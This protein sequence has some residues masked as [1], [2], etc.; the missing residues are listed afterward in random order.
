MDVFNYLDRDNHSTMYTYIKSAHYTL[1]IYTIIC[2]LFLNKVWEGDSFKVHVF[3]RL[4]FIFRER[5]RKGGS[6]TSMC[7]RNIN[8]LPLACAPKGKQAG[9]P[10]ICPDL[11]SNLRPSPLQD[12]P[13]Q[14]SPTSQARRG[15]F[16]TIN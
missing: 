8:W 5:G 16:K 14:L 10:G 1:Q 12:V 2:Q 13:N 15:F 9:N 4:L 6:D 3:K 7:E 11:E